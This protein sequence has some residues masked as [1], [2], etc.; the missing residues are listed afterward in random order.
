LSGDFLALL[1][2]VKRLFAA[3]PGYSVITALQLPF[4]QTKALILIA[5]NLKDF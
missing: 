4:I 1:P 3:F 2:T 5:V